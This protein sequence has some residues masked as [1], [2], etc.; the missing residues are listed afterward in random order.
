MSKYLYKG[1]SPLQYG[2]LF[3][4]N[5]WENNTVDDFETDDFKKYG[6][7]DYINIPTYIK[8]VFLFGIEKIYRQNRKE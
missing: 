2:E 3:I 1:K 7:S 4:D 8:G 6:V 5:F